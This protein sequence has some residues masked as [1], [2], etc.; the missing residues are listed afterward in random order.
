M[1]ADSSAT[2]DRPVPVVINGSAG[3]GDVAAARAVFEP[4][5]AAGRVAIRQTDSA[6]VAPAVRTAR[7]FGAGEIVVVGG[8]G[9]IQRSA[10]EVAGDGT[11]LVA[12]PGGTLN[13]FARRYG[14][15][16][17]ASAAALV[18]R[19]PVADVPLGVADDTLFL[20][21]VVVGA[22]PEILRVRERLE[23]L[24]GKWPAAGLGFAAALLRR[25]R[26]HYAIDWDGGRIERTT[27]MVWIGLG[28]G[29]W[30]LSHRVD[31]Q[32]PAPLLEVVILRDLGRLATAAWLARLARAIRSGRDGEAGDDPAIERL[33]ARWL[34][35]RPLDADG[36]APAEDA[37]RVRREATIAATLDGDPVVFPS[38]LFVSAVPGALRIRVPS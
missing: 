26:G 18:G 32:V 16:T 25:P 20:N 4:L 24:V 9:S 21:T 29:S 11:I 35:I 17:L 37:A 12:A 1:A 14:I 38:P 2:G 27:G 3:S 23:D 13:H 15:D 8:D 6:G 5:R 31:Q 22:Y 19:G 10:R 28:R 7:S 33:H 30:P 34:I 36:P